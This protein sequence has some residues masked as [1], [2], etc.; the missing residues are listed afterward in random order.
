MYANVP[1]RGVFLCFIEGK[2]SPTKKACA[3]NYIKEETHMPSNYTP[4]YR[5]NQWARP[6]K[7]LME[8]FNADN[9]KIDGAIKAQADGLAAEVSA[10]TALAA[11]T[12][13]KGNCRIETRSY[14]GTGKTGDGVSVSISFSAKPVI[15]FVIGPRCLLAADCASGYNTFIGYISNG[16]YGSSFNGGGVGITWSGNTAVLSVPEGYTD[17]NYA[18]YSYKVIAFLA[19]DA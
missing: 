4:N 6:D 17:L 9:A 2:A 11:L 15:F 10:R 5:L 13:K 19:A 16:I 14:T 3:L 12:A 18:N 1:L 7:V 8:D